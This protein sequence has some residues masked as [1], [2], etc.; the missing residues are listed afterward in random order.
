MSEPPRTPDRITEAA[1]R[2]S[3]RETRAAQDP[4]PS[5]GRRFAQIGVLGW[6][7]VGPILLGVLLGGWLDRM[8]GSGITLA[9]ALTVAGAALGLWLALRWMHEQ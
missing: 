9:A 2:A 1:R 3:D 8:L 7:I 6:I 5:L 4:E